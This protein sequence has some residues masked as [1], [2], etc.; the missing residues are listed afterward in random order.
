MR[1]V[2]VQNSNEGATIRAT[3]KKWICCM[4]LCAMYW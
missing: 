1:T 2:H 3:L 4:L